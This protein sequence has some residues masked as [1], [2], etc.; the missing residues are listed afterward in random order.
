MTCPDILRIAEVILFSSGFPHA[1]KLARKIVTVFRHA[2]RKMGT[3]YHYDFGLRSIKGVLEQ[4]S[5]LR[6]L[7]CKQEDESFASAKRA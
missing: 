3:S 5:H 2:D 4:A 1:A 7:L 6:Y